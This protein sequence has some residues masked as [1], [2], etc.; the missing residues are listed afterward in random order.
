MSTEAINHPAHYQTPAGIEAIDVIESYGLVRCSH[1]ANA[2]K[3]L[4]RAGRKGAIATDLGK[5]LW[6]VRR[7]QAVL[8][9]DRSLWPDVT[10]GVGRRH[11]PGDV[12]AAFGIEGCRREATLALLRVPIL[13]GAGRGVKSAAMDRLTEAIGEAIA[14]AEASARGTAA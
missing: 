5:A 8:A 14:E 9:H 12:V 2:L 6:Y 11:L 4:L 1:L 3:Y 13:A 10:H 7:W